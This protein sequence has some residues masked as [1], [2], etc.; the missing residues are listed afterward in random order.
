MR[1]PGVGSL[2]LDLAFR[3]RSPQAVA[4]LL[5]DAISSP[6]PS[7]SLLLGRREG[8]PAASGGPK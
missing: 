8:S 3:T 7:D 2:L 1:E 5:I 4:D 6:T